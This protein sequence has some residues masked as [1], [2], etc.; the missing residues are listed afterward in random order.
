M[1]GI[2]LVYLGSII[3]LIWGAAHLFPT[4][5]IVHGFGSISE[6]SRKIIGIE[7]LAKS[8]A[9]S[10]YMGIL[11]ILVTAIDSRAAASIVAVP[12]QLRC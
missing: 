3:V 7:W 5:I 12:R 1:L 4:R 2:V 6:D 8:V 10:C 11:S 9:V